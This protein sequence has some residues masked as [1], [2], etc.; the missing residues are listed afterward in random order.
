MKGAPVVQ[1][2]TALQ[3]DPGDRAGLVACIQQLR[4]DAT[5][6]RELGRKASSLIQSSYTWRHNAARV[7]SW[8]E[9]LVAARYRPQADLPDRC[10]EG[11]CGDRGD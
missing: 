11:A 10:A 2:E 3:F 4:H 6:R 1:G 9:P 5:L 7:V 8:V